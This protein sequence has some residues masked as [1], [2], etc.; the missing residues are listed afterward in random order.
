[1]KKIKAVNKHGTV[2]GIKQSIHVFAGFI[3]PG[4]LRNTNFLL[5]VNALSLQIGGPVRLLPYVSR[6]H[7][8]I[9]HGIVSIQ[10]VSLP[11]PSTD[12][13]ENTRRVQKPA[14]GIDPE[15]VTLVT[16]DDTAHP[17]KA[18][19]W[20]SVSWAECP[21]C[22]SE[23]VTVLTNA[24]PE[25]DCRDGDPAECLECCYEGRAKVEGD[26]RAWIDWGEDGA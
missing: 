22:G 15:N 13:Q 6:R 16:E 20:R 11:E 24:D 9:E 14:Q 8:R 12:K 26:G 2:A 4:R 7:R 18:R 19:T 23:K 3:R 1:M 25:Y 5:T 21:E 17:G 10:I